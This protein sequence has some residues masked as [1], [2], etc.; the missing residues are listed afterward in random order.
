MNNTSIAL[1]ILQ[2]NG[3]KLSHIYK[4]EFNQTRQ[5]QAI[6]LMIN[7]DKKQHYLTVKRLNSLFK[8]KDRS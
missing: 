1:S 2:V 7:D 6:L 4:S 3:Q 5:R 8:K